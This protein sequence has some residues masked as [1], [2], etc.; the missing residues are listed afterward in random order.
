M[1]IDDI[2]PYERNAR[3]NRKAIPIVAESIREFG[4]KGQIVLESRDNPVIV[5]GHT[6][7]AACKMLG[8]DEIPDERIDFCDGM[9]EDQVKA[10]RLADNKTGEIAKWNS[11]LL[12]TE[13]KALDKSKFDMSR[14]Q[15][16]FKSKYAEKGAER[17]RTDKSYNLHLVNKDDCSG[18]YGMPTMRGIDHKPKG[19]IRFSYALQHQDEPESQEKCVHFFVDDYQFERVWNKP[20]SYLR[21]L[22]KYDCVLT[23]DFSCYLDMPLPM[24]QWNEYRRRALG[25]Y[26]QKNGLKVIPTLSWGEKPSYDFMLDGLPAESTVAVSTVSLKSSEMLVNFQEGMAEAMKRL[27]PKRVLLY[28]GMVDFDFEDAEVVEFEKD[29]AIW[30]D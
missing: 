25:H 19:M 12:Q 3:R 13:V 26:W 15:F 9:S 14:F 23:P 8:W 28:G 22:R 6:R 2:I 10:Y 18:K 24:Q 16:D 27:H 21:I 1:K 7:W 30:A 5:A 4:L 17:L 20:E 11:S 29:V